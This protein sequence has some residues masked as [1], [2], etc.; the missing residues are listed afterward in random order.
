LA[1][2]LS[3]MTPMS[4]AKRISTLRKDKGFTQQTLADAV[5]LHVSQIKRYESG[6]SLPSVNALKNIARTLCVSVDSLVFD[7]GEFEAGDDLKRQFDAISRFPESERAIIRELL[8]G[9]IIKYETRRL[10]TLRQASK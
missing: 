9:M 3:F 4:I 5:D 8:D 6:S 7:E 1:I 2:S 10:D